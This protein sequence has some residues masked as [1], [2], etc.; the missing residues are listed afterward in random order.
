MPSIIAFWRIK[1]AFRDIR[2]AIAAHCDAIPSNTILP[3]LE[4]RGHIPLYPVI[5][6]IQIQ[7]QKKEPRVPGT[8]LYAEY[9]C[10]LAN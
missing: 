6:I 7:I 2:H 4:T 1:M 8:S 10:F 5:E 3:Q 9:N